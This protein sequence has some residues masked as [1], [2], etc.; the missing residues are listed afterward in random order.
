MKFLVSWSLPQATFRPAVARFLQGGGATPA[1]V[2]LIGRWRMAVSGSPSWKR[3]M[4]RPSTPGSRSGRSFCPCGRRPSSR[5]PTPAQS[6]QRCTNS[7]LGPSWRQLDSAICDMKQDSKAHRTT[8]SVAAYDA[9]SLRRRRPLASGC[10][11]RLNASFLKQRPR[12]G[13]ARPSGSSGKCPSWATTSRP[14]ATCRCSSGTVRPSM[15]R[16]WSRSGSSKPRERCSPMPRRSRFRRC[17][18]G[19]SLRD[20]HLG[21]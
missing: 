20:Q 18:V 13:T 4:P 16:H 12:S 19:S 1:G 14:R 2:K 5:T 17:G 10:A 9:A 8:G 7:T 6:W 15:S 3:P 21:R 11:P